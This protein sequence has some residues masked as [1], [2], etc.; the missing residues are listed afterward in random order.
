MSKSDRHSHTSRSVVPLAPP[1][2]EPGTDYPLAGKPTPLL[3]KYL[4]DRPLAWAPDQQI[5]YRD[6]K[7]LTYRGFFERIQRLANVLT[8]L[9]IGN[10]DRVGV[11]DYDSHRYLELYFAVPM[12]GA[13]LHTVNIRLS[14]DQLC[15]TIGHAEDKAL[16][17]HTDFVSLVEQMISRLP[18]VQHRVLLSDDACPAKS[19]AGFAGEYEALLLSSPTE[20]SF[21]DFEE[22]T[23]ATLFYTTGTTGEPKGVFYT[24]RQIVLHTFIVGFTL[25]TGRHPVGLS[26]DDV[27][28]PLTPMFHAHAWGV[29]Y[30]ATALGLKQI[31]PGR[32]EPHTLVKL[33]TTHQPTFSH[34]VPTI[35]RTLLHNP[36]F[37]DLDLSQLKMLIGGSALTEDLGRAS[38]ARGIRLLTGYGMSETC[39]VV[40][41]GQAKPSLSKLEPEAQADL[42]CRATLLT[43]F[44][45]ARIVDDQGRTLPG[46]QEH[47]GELVLQAP[48]LTQG[49]FKAPEQSGHLWRNGWLHTGD[50]GT[51]DSQNYLRITDRIKDV[52]KIGGEWIS[53]F[54]LENALN[55]H[56]AVDEVAV[57]GLPDPKWGERPH[58]L[59]VLLDGLSSKVSAQD[60]VAHLHHC[61][62]FGSI[63]KRAIL[64]S[65]QIV[66]SLPKTSV[67]K[68]DKKALR[69]RLNTSSAHPQ[70]HKGSSPKTE[71]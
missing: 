46:G 54:E 37:R 30:M 10:G 38:R 26:T 57:I 28:L 25:A 43:P 23:V 68:L 14:P 1:G 39:P 6:L 50:V 9:G 3:L 5:I 70:K 13:V 15:F 49:Y 63:H 62:E 8:Q 47:A 45:R 48:W 7:A 12:I 64:T 20:F 21:P 17:I 41:L 53:S 60:L 40:A 51:L 65:I 29:P 35:L 69:A 67:G 34:G 16:F 66:E 22:D 71:V 59:V 33:I 11:L 4:L 36:A 18:T 24:H 61:I 52:I 32:F 2:A 58:A 55:Q 42:L 19:K 27:Y 56:P 31:Y 44:V